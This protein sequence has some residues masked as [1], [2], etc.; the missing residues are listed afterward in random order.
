[1]RGYYRDVVCKYK[2]NLIHR[3]VGWLVGWIMVMAMSFA[4]KPNSSLLSFR[5]QSPSPP[6]IVTTPPVLPISYYYYYYYE[7]L[8]LR[9]NRGSL[10]VRRG[11]AP[12]ASTYIFAFLF[13]L[14]LLAVTIFTSIQISDKLDR[15]YYQEVTLIFIIIHSFILYRC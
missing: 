15:D 1:M 7:K 3:L 8:Q 11:G 12:G 14:S 9:R 13:P 10:V 4:V 5:R 2:Y 6:Q